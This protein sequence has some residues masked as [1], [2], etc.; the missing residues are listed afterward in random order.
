M[1]S[2]QP[3]RR[4][5]ASRAAP[6]VALALALTA[7][8]FAGDYH[9]R[10]RQAEESTV[11]ASPAKYNPSKGY[12]R[13]DVRA[14]FD[15]SQPEP[16][17]I[18]ERNRVIRQDA[19]SI[20]AEC[21]RAARGD[22]KSWQ[23]KT[24]PYRVALKQRVDALQA[25]TTSR[26]FAPERQYEALEGKAGFP[27]FELGSREHLNYLYDPATLDDF[28]RDRPV[29]AAGRWLRQRGVE[30]IFVPVPKMTEVYVERF[31]DPCPED[32]IIA[33][34][35]RRTILEMLSEDVEVMDL[36]RVFR[37][38]RYT[39]AEY[40]YNTG[41]THW[42]PRG[43]RIAAKQI[44]DRI[45]RYS[46]GAKARFGLPLF[47]TSFGPYVLDG[48][49]G[50]L[51]SVSGGWA[52]LNPDQRSRSIAAQTTT[53]SE[54]LYYDGRTLD[55]E[56]DRPS[57]IL[58]IGNSYLKYFRDQLVR[59]LNLPVRTRGAS[60]MATEAFADLLRQSELLDNCRVVVWVTTEQHMTHFKPLPPPIMAALEK[61]AESAQ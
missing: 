13:P 21:Q 24:T 41:D 59:E 56:P 1:A 15:S 7:S 38:L 4:S 53:L 30:L 5:F 51:G 37:E 42:A 36:A 34:H 16:R 48:V 10:L 2:V 35:V 3:A 33:P 54:V 20:R 44:A 60:G 40:L 23:E 45:E 8:F 49:V 61:R 22:W 55:D 25:L 43:M 31:L 57:P 28:R 39:D 47:T 9:R 32:C 12:P 18:A 58:L 6:I 50:G 14:T 29:V 19:E 52:A 11:I 17:A 27:L 46:F 26:A